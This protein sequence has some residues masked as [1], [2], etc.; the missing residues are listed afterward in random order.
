MGADVKATKARSALKL[1]RSSRFIGSRY[2]QDITGF[3]RW[4][5]NYRT[6]RPDPTDVFHSVRLGE[7][8]NWPLISFRL[9]GSAYIYWVL[10]L[11]N[12]YHDAFKGPQIGEILRIPTL[13]RIIAVIQTF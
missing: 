3:G 13:T 4:P 12:K 11:A 10:P 2:Y 8:Y 1:G 6:F 7:E 5:F 9:Y